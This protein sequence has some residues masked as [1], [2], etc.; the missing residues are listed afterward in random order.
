MTS[1][2]LWIHLAL[3]NVCR[4]DM[5]VICGVFW[6]FI[7]TC[8]WLPSPDRDPP[9]PL[10]SC[11]PWFYIWKLA[12]CVNI[13]IMISCC[14]AS[15]ADIVSFASCPGSSLSSMVS[16]SQL[17]Y[18]LVWSTSVSEKGSGLPPL[19]QCMPLWNTT[20]LKRGGIICSYAHSW[21]RTCY[22]TIVIFLFG[23]NTVNI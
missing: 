21:P 8:M 5:L 23:K 22:D 2:R 18:S 13:S 3:L 1:S 6:V 14:L 7:H 11:Y 20:P 4:L 9:S 17:S 16:L 12:N 19:P 15:S 10:P